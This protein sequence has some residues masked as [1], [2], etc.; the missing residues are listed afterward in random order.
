M[1]WP[2]PLSRASKFLTL[3]VSAGVELAAFVFASPTTAQTYADIPI[4]SFAGG[5][6]GASPRASVIQASDGNLYGTTLSGGSGSYGTVFKISN[7][8]TSPT[9]TVIHAFT[10][11][12]DGGWPYSPLLQASDGNLY[13][14]TFVGGSGSAC[15]GGSC[16][17][18]FRIGNLSTV[19]TFSVIY[20]FAGGSD[21]S[22]PE[23]ALIQASDS[24]LYGTTPYGG[25]SGSGTVF[26]ITNLGTT[27]V[28]SIV[29]S[30]SGG[31][32]DGATPRVALVQASDGNLYGTTDSG[33]SNGSG[34][35]FKIRIQSGTPTESVIYNFPSSTLEYYSSLIQASDG[36]LYGSMGY[37]GPG[38]GGGSDCGQVYRVSNLATSPTFVQIYSFL[39]GTDGAVPSALFQA[40]DGFLYGTT[41]Y[42]GGTTDCGGLGCGTVF[43]LINLAGTPTESV[44]YSFTGGGDGAGPSASVI[45]ASDRNLYGTAQNGGT[46]FGTVF[47]IVNTN[48]HLAYYTLAPCRL[49]DTRPTSSAPYGGPSLAGGSQTNYLVTGYCGIPAGAK[50]LSANVTAV[51]PQAGG[52]LRLF[53]TLQGSAPSSTMNFNADRTRANNVISSLDSNGRMTIQC[54]MLAGS[55]TNVLFDVNGYFR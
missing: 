51:T 36:N 43:Q 41:V 27:P 22:D 49:I 29:Y 42:G 45:Q 21:G 6:D 47:K 54:D 10:G 16:G 11:G 12:V 37:V 25:S 34:T 35:I 33:G 26:K 13:G 30:F 4:Y 9:E 1:K 28:E 50:A 44:I 24:N 40:N 17:V 39:G 55:S 3:I 32:F 14:T 38:C 19:P 18:V 52:D 31:M 23:A 20:D 46:S 48:D 2:V 53:P 8:T 5:S 7:P 15:G